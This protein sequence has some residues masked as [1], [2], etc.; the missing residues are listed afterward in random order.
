MLTL[1]RKRNILLCTLRR[2]EKQRLAIPERSKKIL[3]RQLTMIVP[4][5]SSLY[6]NSPGVGRFRVRNRV[7]AR[8]SAP[9]HCFSL[10][11]NVNFLI[12]FQL[13]FHLVLGFQGVSFL[14]VYP[15]KPCIM[16]ALLFSLIRSRNIVRL[17]LLCMRSS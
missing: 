11:S 13:S 2:T 15:L 16:Y 12:N 17:I 9:V 8:F 4:G 6:S 5:W 10:S 7:G 14:L 3:V 1:I